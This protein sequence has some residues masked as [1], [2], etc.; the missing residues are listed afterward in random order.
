[1]S[2][3]GTSYKGTQYDFSDIRKHGAGIWFGFHSISS[4]ETTMEERRMICGRIRRT[5]EIFKCEECRGHFRDYINANPPEDTIG[6]PGGLFYWTVEFRNA[7]QRRV[8]REKNIQLPIYDPEIMYEIFHDMNAGTC[9]DDCSG[10]SK[11]ESKKETVPMYQRAH[12]SPIERRYNTEDYI[13]V[14]AKNGSTQWMPR[15]RN[16]STNSNSN[17]LYIYKR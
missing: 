14:I 12:V 6:T 13:Q 1:M 15:H 7:V 4:G 11:T 8:M 3:H 5:A 9:D 16:T 2:S 17:G 10:E